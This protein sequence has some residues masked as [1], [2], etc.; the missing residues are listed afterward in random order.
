MNQ[1][2]V[3]LVEWL[4]V[5]AIIAIIAAVAFV[6]IDPA[7]RFAEAR[8]AQRWTDVSTLMEGVQK[9]FV[10]TEAALTNGLQSID[11]ATETVQVITDGSAGIT[12]GG[13]CAT[14]MI[15]ASNCDA[16]LS[17]LEG[18]YI[19]AV[20]MD[21]SS[22]GANSQYYVNYNNGIFTVGACSPEEEKDGSTPTIRISR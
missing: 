6:A 1:Q 4:I 17:G 12:C 3:T 2:G 14:E 22:S 13:R 10:D 5:I 8:N 16:D 7:A 18:A 11:S 21:P 19:A 15:A 9:A 20:P